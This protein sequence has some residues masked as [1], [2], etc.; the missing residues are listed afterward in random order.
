MKLPVR[1]MRVPMSWRRERLR[2]YGRST[3]L[4]LH[5]TGITIEG[6]VPDVDYPVFMRVL[7]RAV[8][9]WTIRTI[10]FS[11]INRCQLVR[12]NRLRLAILIATILLSS[13]L[14]TWLWDQ[15]WIFSA[16]ILAIG[17]IQYFFLRWLLKNC[18]DI[19]YSTTGSKPVALRLRFLSSEDEQYWFSELSRHRLE[20]AAPKLALVAKSITTR[21]SIWQ[22][23]F[24]RGVDT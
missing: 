11:R 3:V 20:S 12:R 7:W 2:F 16:L 23:M 15:W 17:A 10:P 19:E 24:R 14:L 18:I 13:Y 6:M 5:E 22:R 9:N 1:S 4:N 8:S 21:R